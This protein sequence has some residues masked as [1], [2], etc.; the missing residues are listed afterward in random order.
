MIEQSRVAEAVT[1]R[2]EAV[3]L[4]E[5][6]LSE[7]KEGL[8]RDPSTQ[9]VPL[10]EAFNLDGPEPDGLTMLDRL[11]LSADGVLAV[12]PS[13]MRARESFYEL[14]GET[15]GAVRKKEASDQQVEAIWDLVTLGMCQF[16][17]EGEMCLYVSYVML[18]APR[19]ILPL[20]MKTL[21]VRNLPRAIKHTLVG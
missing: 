14:L 19:D 6:M 13:R 8:P 9:I 2:R 20:G 3:F 4:A 16:A 7:A 11:F 21:I 18:S 5:R 10:L 1:H 15:I 17:R 12:T